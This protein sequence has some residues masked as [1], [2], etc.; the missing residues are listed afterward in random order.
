MGME[1]TEKDVPRPKQRK[2][3]TNQKK[4]LLTFKQLHTKNLISM[5]LCATQEQLYQT[6]RQLSG[7]MALWHLYLFTGNQS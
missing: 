2:T 6:S 5:L 3:H 1:V 4:S 7:Q